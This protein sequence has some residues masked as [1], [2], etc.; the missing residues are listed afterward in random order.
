[1]AKQLYFEC[2]SGISGDMTV[3]AMLDLGA[4]RAV[5]MQALDSLPLSGYT[6][7]IGRRAV[8]GIDACDFDVVL[9]APLDNHDH[10]MAYLYG[11]GHHDHGHHHH[12]HDH[13]H[14][15]DHGDHDHHHGHVHRTLAE[16]KQILAGGTMTDGARALAETIFDHLAAAE[17]KAHGSDVD[18]VHFHEVGA[19]DSIVDITAAA[20]CF[21]NLK[22]QLGFTDV[23]IPFINEG[24]GHVRCAH[25]RMPVP[26]PAVVNLAEAHGLPLR[27]AGLQGERITPTGA[28]IAATVMTTKTLPQPFTIL[29]TG[30]GAGKRAYTDAANLLRLFL[31]EPEGGARPFDS[32]SDAQNVVQLEANLDDSTGEILGRIV[33]KLISAGALDATVT[34][35]VMKKNRPG[36]VLTVLCRRADQPAL[37]ALIFA[38]TTT[39]GIRSF[40]VSRSVLP[41]TIETV[42][43]PWGPAKVKVTTRDGKRRGVPEFDTVD[44]LAQAAGVPFPDA[45]AA[46][47]SAW[48]AQ[49]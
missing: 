13:D 4:D 30:V 19:V 29:K 38:E 32:A 47:L 1:M 9:D 49:S 10:D 7:E 45:Y 37:E 16:V 25:G 14:S 20:V 40:P 31:I 8:S 15:H 33:T 5:L 3:G 36:A 41:R 23:V 46:V 18:H 21:D 27:L 28:A 34:P 11:S 35:V 2:S 44:Q 17:A 26:V 24:G 39:I 42:D 12:D 48:Q 43:T 22:T 6:I